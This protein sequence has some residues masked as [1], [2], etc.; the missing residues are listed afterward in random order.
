MLGCDGETCQETVVQRPEELTIAREKWPVLWIDVEGLS[1]AES[2]RMI[3][4]VF[5]IGDL[6]LEDATT[7]D[8]RPKVEVFG[9]QVLVA[10]RMARFDGEV[11]VTATGS[12]FATNSP[13]MAS[14]ASGSEFVMDARGS[15]TSAPTRSALSCSTR[16]STAIF[17]CSN[18]LATGSSCSRKRR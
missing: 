7:P 17:P 10:A 18:S 6:A 9:H 13:T 12:R 3:G 4:D 8:E 14:T 15:A 5:Q 16:L 1:D 2:I 11:I